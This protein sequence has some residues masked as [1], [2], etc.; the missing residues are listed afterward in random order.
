MV[1]GE[2]YSASPNPFTIEGYG[3]FY[4]ESGCSW[5]DWLGS[6]YNTRGYTYDEASGCIDLGDGYGVMIAAPGDLCAEMGSYTPVKI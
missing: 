4:Y 3:V 5:E 6:L 2:E 1:S